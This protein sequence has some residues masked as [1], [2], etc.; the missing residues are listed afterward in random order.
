MRTCRMASVGFAC[1][2]LTVAVATAA[3]TN[4]VSLAGTNVSSP[5]TSWGLS[6]TNIQDAITDTVAGDTVLVSNGTYY[7][8]SQISIANAITVKGL[9]GAA[10]TIVA[11]AASGT[12]APYHRIFNITANATLDGFT[13]Q[14][15]CLTNMLPAAGTAQ[16]AGLWMSAGTAQYCVVRYNSFLKQANDFNSA[17]AGVYLSGNAWLQFSQIVSNSCGAGGSVCGDGAGVYV[18]GDNCVVYSNT[19]AWNTNADEGGGINL[20]RGKAV[21]CTIENNMAFGGS[22][23]YLVNY[24]SSLLSNCIIRYNSTT[25][26]SYGA[27]GVHAGNGPLYVTDCTIVSNTSTVAGV[28]GGLSAAT[29]GGGPCYIRRCSIMGNT[30]P[31]YAG[32]YVNMGATGNRAVNLD[33]CLIANNNGPYSLYIDAVKDVARIRNCTIYAQK[34]YGITLTTTG[35]WPV[36]LNTIVYGHGTNIYSTNAVWLADFL[37]NSFT[38]CCSPQLTAPGYNNVSDNPLFADLTAKNYHLKDVSPCANAG[39]TAVWTDYHSDLER[40]DHGSLVNIGCYETLVKT[41]S[42]GS[43]VLVR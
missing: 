15:G 24:N 40:V 23:A 17:G 12:N 35:V 6:T 2:A 10:E 38:F 11:R 20:G 7:I 9:A 27:A 8:N 5:F 1:V 43:M 41:V 18:A 4:Y 13:A 32:A 14:N 39:S 21:G 16:G 3:K 37:T 28:P 19:I 30:A 22:G 34:D 42:H 25:P 33:N 36:V 26:N 29:A 31:K